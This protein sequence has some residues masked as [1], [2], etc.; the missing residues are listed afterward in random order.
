MD[1]RL[2]KNTVLVAAVASLVWFGSIIGC[3]QAQVRD[4]PPPP[5][6]VQYLYDTILFEIAPITSCTP[7]A[8]AL[9]YFRTRLEEYRICRRE[10]VFFLTHPEV[11]RPP[12]IPW[13]GRSIRQF[14]RMFRQLEDPD[15]TD[16]VGVIFVSYIAGPVFKH[17]GKIGFLGGVQYSDT[18]FAVWK[19]GAG[20]REAGVLMH[21]FA[22]LIGVKKGSKK[23]LYHCPRRTCVMWTTV[24]SPY[25]TFCKDCQNELSAIIEERS[26][27][28]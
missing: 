20:G 23:P 6:R 3:N 12:T 22:H 4:A 24:G 10:G 5:L 16:R 2:K 15:P 17:G 27:G 19:D 26:Q 14:E 1:S 8:A 28:L 25:A 13:T 7:D 21:E 18:A 9:S 11:N